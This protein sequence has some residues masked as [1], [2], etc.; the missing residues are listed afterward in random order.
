MLLACHPERNE[1]ESK[2]L[3][4]RAC[5]R[6]Y[7]LLISSVHRSVPYGVTDNLVRRDK[8]EDPIASQPDMTALNRQIHR[9]R[10]AVPAWGRSARSQIHPYGRENGVHHRGIVRTALTA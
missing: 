7:E 10:R 1:V 6:C 8:E 5:P 2:D 3:Q 4:P 9:L